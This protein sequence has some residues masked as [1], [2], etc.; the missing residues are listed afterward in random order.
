MH[1]RNEEVEAQ[2]RAELPELLSLLLLVLYLMLT[3]PNFTSQ[4]MSYQ[5]RLFAIIHNSVY[6]IYM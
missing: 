1:L 4:L 5:N 3:C 6:M 2:N